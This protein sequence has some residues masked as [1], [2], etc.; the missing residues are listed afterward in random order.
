MLYG[1]IAVIA[2][3]ALIAAR[4]MTLAKLQRLNQSVLEAEKETRRIRGE[5]KVAENNKAVAELDLK[6]EEQKKKT[7]ER[8]I[9]K[10]DQELDKMDR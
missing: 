5:L 3:F 7:L 9:Q 6:T 8:Q 4:Y 10:Y 2:L 1:I